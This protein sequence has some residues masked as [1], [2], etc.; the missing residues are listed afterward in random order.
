MARRGPD[1]MGRMTHL[2]VFESIGDDYEQIVFGHDAAVGLRTI[3]SVYSTARG[4]ALGGTRIYPYA[5]EDAALTDALRLGKAMAF[6]AA[7]ADLALG[8]GKAVIIADPASDKTPGL[9]RA[10]GAQVERLGGTYITTADVGS[11]VQDLDIIAQTT[12]WV[13]G[14]S[15]GS[16]DPSPVTAYGV[17]HGMRAVAEVAFGEPSLAG[18]HVV[19][20]GTGKVGGALARLLAEEGARLTLADLRTPTELAAELGAEI[21]DP[22]E[23]TSLECDVFAPCAMGS[24]VTADTLSRLRCKAIAGAANNQLEDPSL[25]RALTERGIVYAPD[26]VINAGGLINVEDELH[27]YDAD[28]AHAKAAAIAGTLR[29][30]FEIAASE[31]IPTAE[32]ADRLALGRIRSAGVSFK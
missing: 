10:Y 21:C 23:A 32:A 8:G 1:G 5:S 22:S 27:G 13:T 28:R 18:R 19:L 17:W 2:S 12:R 7:C 30:V 9:L 24:V 6:K 11:T 29:E 16:G 31:A 20:Q 15:G 4:P 25:G 3:I 26:Y 14:T